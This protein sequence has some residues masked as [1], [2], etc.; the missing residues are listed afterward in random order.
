L[1]AVCSVADTSQRSIDKIIETLEKGRNLEEIRGN[2]KFQEA[3]NILK[4]NTDV[5]VMASER[6][7]RIV[8]SLRNF[9]RLEEADFQEADIHE[10]LESTL[11]LL[12]NEIKNRINVVKEFGEIPKIL[13]YPSQLNQVFMNI[14]VNASQAIKERGTITIKTSKED[15]KIMVSISDDGEGIKKENLKKIFDSG[16]TT[17]G[18]GIGTGLGLSISQNIIKDHKG[19]IEV[20]SEGGR[21]SEFIITLPIEQENSI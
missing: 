1:R 15:N 8:R 20:K 13:C 14:L 12:H 16:F 3:L 21:G 9:A 5:T 2:K 6:I 18:V 4:S 10:G 7:T 19:N 11:T 17:R